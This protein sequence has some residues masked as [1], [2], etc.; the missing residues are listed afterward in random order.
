MSKGGNRRRTKH[1]P[2][3]VIECEWCGLVFLSSREL[4]RTCS[5][6]H[7]QGLA[8]WERKGRAESGPP[9]DART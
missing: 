2:K 8:R 7:R 5:D 9:P 3:Y 1:E 4:T 6:A